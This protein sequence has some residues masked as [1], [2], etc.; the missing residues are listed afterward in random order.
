MNQQAIH[1]PSYPVMHYDAEGR[2]VN[3]TAEPFAPAASPKPTAL[4]RFLD[5]MV[6]DYEHW[7][8]GIGYDMAALTE[9]SA[10]EREQL[11]ILLL[12]RGVNDWRDIQALAS[13]NTERSLAALRQALKSDA[14]PA[15]L[16]LNAAELAEHGRTA[17]IAA[18]LETAQWFEG[19]GPA[20][21]LAAENPA[22]AVVEALWRGLET[23]G[24]DVAVHFAALLAYLHRLASEPFDIEQRPFFLTFNTDDPLE[25]RAAI[26]E[27]RARIAQVQ[28]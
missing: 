25:R 13:L 20:L 21:D 26:A 4:Q 24:G 1:D 6:I 7:H 10:E 2:F 18:E 28:P 23:R 11:E 27:L 19:L 5:S 8:D 15:T 14:L 9:M 17:A 22:P 12:S 3:G 16:A